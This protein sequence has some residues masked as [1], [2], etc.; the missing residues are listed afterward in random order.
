MM[1][2]KWTQRI[3]KVRRPIVVVNA[4]LGQAREIADASA[5]CSA[6]GRTPV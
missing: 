1:Y 3:E 5:T 6:V 4:P 2:A